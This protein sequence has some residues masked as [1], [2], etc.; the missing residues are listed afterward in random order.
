[1]SEEEPDRR[2]FWNKYFD[3]NRAKNQQYNGDGKPYTCLITG[4]RCSSKGCPDPKDRHGEGK[5]KTPHCGGIVS[6]C[7][8]APV[9][10]EGS[11][12]YQHFTC[13]KCGKRCEIT[14]EEEIK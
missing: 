14:G 2:L 12:A 9:S 7:C 8:S 4:K 11:Y 6:T 3:C 1:M 5:M 10:V 13:D